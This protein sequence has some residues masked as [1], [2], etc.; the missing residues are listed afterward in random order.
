MEVSRINGRYFTL[1]LDEAAGAMD[2]DKLPPKQ[3]WD[4]LQQLGSRIVKNW[5]W[6]ALPDAFYRGIRINSWC[7]SF[8][9]DNID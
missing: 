2:L 6:S 1:Q 4:N 9:L 7:L 3:Q 8:S 5:E